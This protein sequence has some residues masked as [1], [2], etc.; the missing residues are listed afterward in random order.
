MRILVAPLD[1]GLGHTTRCVPV[2]QHLQS[3]GHT[4]VFAGNDWQRQ[5][6]VKTFPGI[7]TI[8]LEGYNVEYSKKGGGFMAKLF[9]QLPG[10]LKTIRYEHQWVQQQA[11]LLQINGII[12]DNRYG[13]YHPTIPSVIMTH[14][15]LA[16]SGMG[17]FADNLLKRIHYKQLERFKDCWVVDVP[18]TPN[19]AGKLAHPD[20]MPANAQYIGLLSQVEP[21]SVSEQHLLI[22]FSGP[23]PQRTLLADMLW[24]QVQQYKGKVVFVEGSD[25]VTD[26]GTIP[27]HITYHK[28]ITKEVL[29]PLI[30][31]ANMV[32]CRSGY[33]TLMDLVVLNKKAILVPTPGQTE[34]EFLGRHLH[35]EGVFYHAPQ[36]GL[37][38]L[39]A[40]KGAETFPFH[41]LPLA[42]AQYQYK[43]VLENWLQKL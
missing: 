43:V 8:H 37:D 19:L 23:E 40:L 25:K 12:S 38:L 14:Q 32:V 31:A 6:I 3:L 11:E 1:W 29:Q 28:R 5:Y 16:Q 42:N 21:M 13:L 9:A 15:V 17:P 10:L 22:L 2:I 4:A 27:A 20:V 7:E 34:Q 24:Q 35:K 26:K 39:T 36:K 33:S 41:K 30:A 18:G